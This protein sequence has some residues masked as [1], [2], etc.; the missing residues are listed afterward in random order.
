MLVG[1]SGVGKS[2]LLR[3]L[4]PD[5]AASVG[6]LMRDD[7]GRHTTTATRLYAAAR[8][9]R[10]HRF[11]GRARFR[12]GA[13]RLSRAALGFIEIEAL[14]AAVPLRRLPAPA[15][16]GLRGTRGR[17]RRTSARAATRAT[18]GCAVCIERLRTAHGASARSRGRSRQRWR[19]AMRVRQRA[20][21]DVF[22]LPA[23]RHAVRNAAGRMPRAR[24]SSEKKCAV[25]SPSTV[26]LVARI[27]SRNAAVVEQRLEFARAE[28]S[29]PMPS[30]GERW[31]ISTK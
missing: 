4:V 23:H 10:D 17:G 25:A 1:Q 12:A 30:S 31:P 24:T 21:V 26:G 11:A 14:S 18:G 19:P 29:G 9:R 20:A 6:E 27:T 3:A 13:R 8:R 28:L 2:S 15:R 5:S 7:E 22:Q 16:A